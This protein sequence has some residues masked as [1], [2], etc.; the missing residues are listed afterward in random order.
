YG[1]MQR[2]LTAFFPWEHIPPERQDHLALL[3]WLLAR[4]T[5][6]ARR[7]RCGDCLLDDICVHRP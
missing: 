4:H 5:C 1:E 6:T 3:F 7:P 2:C